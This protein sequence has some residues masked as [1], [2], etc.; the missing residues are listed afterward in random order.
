[1]VHDLAATP[2]EEQPR[3]VCY[4]LLHTIGE[5]TFAK[6][7]LARHILTGIEVAVKIIRWERSHRPFREVQS[8]KTLNH[9]NIV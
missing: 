4:E 3:V 7:K 5:G 1:M 6:V 8:M 2:S 9:P